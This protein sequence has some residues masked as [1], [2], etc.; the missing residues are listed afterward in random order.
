M[1]ERVKSKYSS[2]KKINVIIK[3]MVFGVADLNTD[4]LDAV[5]VNS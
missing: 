3:T 1:W 5:S 4:N 2:K